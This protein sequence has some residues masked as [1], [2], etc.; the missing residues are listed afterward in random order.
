MSR[1]SFLDE[2]GAVAGAFALAAAVVAVTLLRAEALGFA[3]VKLALL[4]G[5]PTAFLLG[6]GLFG[7]ALDRLLERESRR[8][9]R[10]ASA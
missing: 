6:M 7:G 2:F 8:Q 5:A 3:G 4:V 10:L 9:R 1:P